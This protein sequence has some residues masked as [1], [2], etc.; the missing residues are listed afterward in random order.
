MEEKT[1]EKAVL[2]TVYEAAYE[3]HPEGREPPRVLI[4][5]S[6][7]RIGKPASCFGD[8][9]KLLYSGS[10]ALS[11]IRHDQTVAMVRVDEFEKDS[12]VPK[13]LTHVYGEDV[14]A[15]NLKK[16]SIKD[17]RN[18]K[19]KK[20]PW[21]QIPTPHSISCSNPRIFDF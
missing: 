21:K 20:H 6:D 18:P 2:S 3:E 14:V 17:I 13:K 15:A 1:E 12:L 4:V 11:V 16:M 5:M 10:T 8:S 9:Y 7:G 19:W